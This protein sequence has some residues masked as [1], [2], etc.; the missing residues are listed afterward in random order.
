MRTGKWN[1]WLMLF[2][3]FALNVQCVQQVIKEPVVRMGPADVQPFDEDWYFARYG[4]Q[5]DGTL[6]EEPKGLEA[7]ETDDSHWRKLDLPHDWAVE[8][9]FR[10]EL[11]GATGSFTVTATSDGLKRGEI[12]IHV[13]A[14][15]Q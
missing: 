14:G 5:A 8:G 3:V 10:I 13:E 2:F 15:Q 7:V 12:S 4:L 6:K 9:P 11:N 1:V